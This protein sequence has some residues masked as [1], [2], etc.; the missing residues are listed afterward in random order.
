MNKAHGRSEAATY[1]RLLTK[2]T[3]W[4]ESDEE[5]HPRYTCCMAVGALGSNQGAV[6][7]IDY[8]LGSKKFVLTLKTDIPMTAVM[9]RLLATTPGEE[10][11]KG[12]YWQITSKHEFVAFPD[13]PDIKTVAKYLDTVYT[14]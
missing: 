5:L 9:D 3:S 12:F 7:V 4:L 13:L 10:D 1:N 11:E 8:R 6:A 14:Q 2:I